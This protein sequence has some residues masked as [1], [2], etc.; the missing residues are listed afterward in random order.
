MGD[1]EPLDIEAGKLAFEQGGP[2]GDARLIAKSGIDDGPAIAI[3]QKVN[4]HVVQL[5]GQ[6]ESDPEQARLDFDNLIGTRVVIPGV[7]QG[8]D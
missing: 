8:I 6:L 3:G 7:P 4:I 5:E 2:G 1:D